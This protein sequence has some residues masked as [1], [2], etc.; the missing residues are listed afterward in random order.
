MANKYDEYNKILKQYKTKNEREVTEARR[1]LLDA[2]KNLEVAKSNL[3]KAEKNCESA[4]KL[5]SE[6]ESFGNV[7]KAFDD[8]RIKSTFVVEKRIPSADEI[9]NAVNN[10]KAIAKDGDEPTI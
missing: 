3:A 8:E 4:A 5:V 6:L 9:S 7:L 2:E 1:A 10:K